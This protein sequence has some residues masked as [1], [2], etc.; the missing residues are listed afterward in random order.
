MLNIYCI[1]NFLSEV[2]KV[3]EVTKLYKK[4]K[5]MVLRLRKHTSHVQIIH[6]LKN[7]FIIRVGSEFV[8]NHFTINMININM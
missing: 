4:C 1:I 6:I 5:K 3:F 2:K 7:S 8:I